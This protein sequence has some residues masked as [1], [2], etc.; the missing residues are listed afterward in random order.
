MCYIYRTYDV[1]STRYANNLDL[2]SGI[3]KMTKT[4]ILICTLK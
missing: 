4:E 2:R 1:L 3:R